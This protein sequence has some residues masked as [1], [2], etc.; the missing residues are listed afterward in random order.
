MEVLVRMVIPGRTGGGD[1]G[2]VFQNL[3]LEYIDIHGI[4][5]LLYKWIDVLLVVMQRAPGLSAPA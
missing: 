5:G 4:G 3:P 2:E 1:I